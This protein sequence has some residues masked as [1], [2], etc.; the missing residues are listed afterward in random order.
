MGK[1]Q[2]DPLAAIV[3]DNPQP[4]EKIPGDHNKR[5]CEKCIVTLLAVRKIVQT[6]HIQ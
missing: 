3:R 5:I 1:M 2:V 6:L 4:L